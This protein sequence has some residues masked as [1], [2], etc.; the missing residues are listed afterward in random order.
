MSVHAGLRRAT[1]VGPAVTPH[2]RALEVAAFLLL[3][4]G[5][6]WS[7]IALGGGPVALAVALWTPGLVALALTRM[8]GAGTV[9]RLGLDRLGWADAYLIAFWLPLAMAAGATLLAATLR[10]GVLEWGRAAE[11]A[12]TLT[13]APLV[14]MLVALGSEVGWRAYLLPRLRP[15][16]LWGSIVVAAVLWTAWHMPL[17]GAPAAE[18]S[19]GDGAVQLAWCLLVG[20]ILGWLLVRTRSPWAPALFAGLL[21]ATSSLPLLFLRE[22]TPW[23]IGSTSPFGLVIPALAVLAMWRSRGTR[24]E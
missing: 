20:T 22:A 9:A 16:G 19:I 7:A 1:L 12:A 13:I 14:N 11:V 18:R 3:V 23:V 10:L 21:G 4:F 8:S 6:G 2:V 5:V 15:L 17:S 24:G